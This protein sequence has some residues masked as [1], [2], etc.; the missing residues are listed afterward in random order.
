MIGR[1]FVLGTK[2]A[3]IGFR[4]VG[5]PGKGP[6]DKESA[7]KAFHEAISSGKYALIII[8]E[9]I[10]SM[11]REEIEEVKSRELYPLIVEIPER[12]GWKEKS[13]DYLEKMVRDALGLGIKG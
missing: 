10:A 4:L 7:L 5:V 13:N 3:V 8:T 1:I 12:E 9:E 6:E 2:E 11:I